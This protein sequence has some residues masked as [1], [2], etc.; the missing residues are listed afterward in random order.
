MYTSDPRPRQ[1][2]HRLSSGHA[3]GCRMILVISYDEAR[4]ADVCSLQG[5]NRCNKPLGTRGVIECGG[6]NAKPFSSFASGPGTELLFLLK[7]FLLRHVRC[8][9]LWLSAACFIYISSCLPFQ[10]QAPHRGSLSFFVF[11]HPHRSPLSGSACSPAPGLCS[12]I[13]SASHFTAIY[14]LT[15]EGTSHS[16]VRRAH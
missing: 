1:Q 15:V 3:V 13:C 14:S 10:A 7:S 11:V 9:P 2:R 16:P 8:P 12:S 6:F 5:A 4:M